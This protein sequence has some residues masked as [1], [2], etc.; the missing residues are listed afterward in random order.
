MQKNT[1][2]DLD[3]KMRV[4]VLSLERSMAHLM[5][6]G[7]LSSKDEDFRTDFTR[8]YG[9][10]CEEKRLAVEML[11][12]I[13]LGSY[14]NDFP[15]EYCANSGCEDVRPEKVN[16]ST[17]KCP[18]CGEFYYKGKNIPTIIRYEGNAYNKFPGRF[19]L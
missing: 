2:L 9:R 3:K 17:W 8:L 14:E 10:I 18:S 6:F 19:R 15:W 1:A 16:N 13:D 7:F 11:G 5:S 4:A 12:A